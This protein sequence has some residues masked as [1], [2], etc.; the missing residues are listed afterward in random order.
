MVAELPGGMPR[1]APPLLYPHSISYCDD[2]TWITSKLYVLQYKPV[3]L[4][5]A[6]DEVDATEID[7]IGCMLAMYGAEDELEP[8]TCSWYTLTELMLQ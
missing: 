6:E 7:G 4:G 3:G 2:P 1:S 5:T 8:P